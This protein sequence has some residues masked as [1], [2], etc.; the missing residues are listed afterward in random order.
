VTDQA[1]TRQLSR[2]LVSLIHYVELH[3]TGWWDRALDRLVLAA[4]WLKAPTTL[5]EVAIFLDAGL[6]HRVDRDRVELVIERETAAGS[7]ITIAED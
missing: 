3:R 4:V 1:P 2:E 7:I 5:D 6:D